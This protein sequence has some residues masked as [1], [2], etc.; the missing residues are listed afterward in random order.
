MGRTPALARRF[1]D[2]LEPV[3]AVT[4]FAPESRAALDA[5]G[6]RG[7]WTGYFAARSA[8]LGIVPADVVAATFYNFTTERVA[9]ALPGAWEKASPAMLLQVR[10]DSAAA[11]LRRSGVAESESTRLAAELTAKAARTAPLDGRPLYAANRAQPWPEDPIAKL[12][13]AVTLL[14]EH[15]GDAHVA[16]LV[17]EGISG[18]QSNVLHAAAGRVPREMIMR[19]RDYDEEQWAG[20]VGQLR[21]RGWLDGDG[22]LTE[23]GRDVKQSIED[24]TDALALGALDALTDDEIITLFQVLTPITRQV[25]AAGDVPAATPMG[26]NRHDLDDDSAHLT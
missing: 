11:A 21:S 4:Y 1:F 8:P 20:Y 18:R 3:H 16:V 24:R 14:R 6:Y 26:L 22:E 13:H 23:A 19:S 5:L 10:S 7:F 17:A 12:W 15:R 25:V 2:R 9:K